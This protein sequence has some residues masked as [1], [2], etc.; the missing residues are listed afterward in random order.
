MVK[1]HH[2]G[3]NGGDGMSDDKKGRVLRSVQGMSPRTRNLLKLTVAIL[4]T[5]AALLLIL[6]LAKYLLPFVIALVISQMFDPFV[7]VLVKAKLNRA[8]AATIAILILLSIAALIILLV[9]LIGISEVRQLA[10]NLPRWSQSLYVAFEELSAR[11]K[12]TIDNLHPQIVETLRAMAEGITATA[13][14]QLNAFASALLTKVI[15]MPRA[16]IFVTITVFS[17]IVLMRD[18]N[19]ILDYFRKQLPP[20][21]MHYTNVIRTDLF[22]ALFGYIRAQLLLMCITFIELMIGFTL[23]GREYVLLMSVIIALVDALPIFG[24]GL[25]LIPYSVV[26]LASGEYLIGAGMVGL[27]FT[28]LIVRQFIEPKVL[29]KQIGMHPLV[30]LFSLYAGLKLWGVIGLIAG[31]ISMLILRNVL[32]V[33]MDGRTIRDIINGVERKPTEHDEDGKYSKE[34]NN[35]KIAVSVKVESSRRDLSKPD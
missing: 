31:P 14:R 4:G 33:Y 1:E 15:S 32:L 20:K 10:E 24:A 35:E 27:Y 34:Q 7:R 26:L 28:I 11:Y 21:W 22:S 5:V 30:T 8:L 13:G 25:F 3:F 2:A 16:I 6:T 17:S 23:L 18:R 12:S 29:G 9:V 19:M